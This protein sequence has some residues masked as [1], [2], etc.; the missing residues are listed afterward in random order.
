[1]AP[2]NELAQRFAR[3]AQ[4]AVRELRVRMENL[5]TEKHGATRVFF[6]PNLSEEG[7]K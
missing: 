7:S 4:T 5:T 6:P 2:D 1:L 3:Q